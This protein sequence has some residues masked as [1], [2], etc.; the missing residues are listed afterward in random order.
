MNAEQRLKQLQATHEH[1]FIECARRVNQRTEWDLNVE[2][3]IIDARKSTSIATVNGVGTLGSLVSVSNAIDTPELRKW[4]EIAA[5]KGAEAAFAEMFNDEDEE[6][7]ERFALAYDELRKERKEGRKGLWSATDLSKFVVKT[8]DC[9]PESI[10]AVAILPGEGTAS[11][12]L[13][14]FESSVSSLLS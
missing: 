4:L 13:L 10:G 9:F 2:C 12:G 7:G 6:A 3:V 8:R 5:E 14:T 11:H 1:A